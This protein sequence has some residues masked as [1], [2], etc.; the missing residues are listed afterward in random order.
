MRLS[1][2]VFASLTASLL[3][4]GA[5]AQSAGGS[6]SGPA[7]SGPSMSGPAMKPAGGMQMNSMGGV[8]IFSRENM[9][10]MIVDREKATKG[11]SADQAAAAR[12]EEMA[13]HGSETPAE[14]QARKAT[15]DSEWLKLT[16]AEKSDAL[17]KL[18]AQMK[19]RG[20][21]APAK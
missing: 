19:A 6:M 20:M 5:M 15:Y 7:M 17:T 11:M 9:A 2:I 8:G 3:A 13:K 1:G 4:S 10:M 12:K 18:D 21:S 14:N 16:A